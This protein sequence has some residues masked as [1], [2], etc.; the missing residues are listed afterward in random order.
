MFLLGLGGNGLEWSDLGP[1]GRS[2][3]ADKVTLVEQ[4]F[5]GVQAPLPNH[6][7]QMKVYRAGM[8]VILRSLGWRVSRARGLFA[9]PSK[10]AGCS[11]R[12][13]RPH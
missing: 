3:R 9:S 7:V 8:F 6:K 5:D 1:K 4:A 10:S 13:V 12:V 11:F 2:S